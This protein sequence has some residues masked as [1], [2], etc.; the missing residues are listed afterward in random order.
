MPKI[1]INPSVFKILLQ[2]AMFDYEEDAVKNNQSKF[3]IPSY[4]FMKIPSWKEKIWYTLVS[5]IMH[6]GTL[7]VIGNYYNDVFDVKT[8]IW[9]HFDDYEITQISDFSEDVY[10][11]ESHKKKTQK[12]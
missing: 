8:V 3:V 6:E 12:N 11:R 1:E 4:F 10:T 7:S 5:M 9:W 2:R